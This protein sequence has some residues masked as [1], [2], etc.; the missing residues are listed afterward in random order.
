LGLLAHWSGR[1]VFTLEIFREKEKMIRTHSHAALAFHC[2]AELPSSQRLRVRYAGHWDRCCGPSVSTSQQEASQ[3]TN[4]TAGAT[5]PIISGS[6]AQGVSTSDAPVYS[7]AKGNVT[8]ANAPTYT[9]T[10]GN[11]AIDNST[12]LDPE[13]SGQAFDAIKTLVGQ[14]LQSTGAAATT[15]AQTVEQQSSNVGDLVQAVLAKDQ[16]TAASTASGGATDWTSLVK[17][18]FGL[19]AAVAALFALPRLFKK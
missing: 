10:K 1:G 6:G 8:V 12:T 18:G 17:W 11:V 13:I 5:S 7:A 9:A 3:T 4:S 14:A 16:T 15:A 2:L 19:M